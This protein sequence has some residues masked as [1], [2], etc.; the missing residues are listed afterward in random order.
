[1]NGTQKHHA[2]WKLEASD[3]MFYDSMCVKFLG[4]A[5]LDSRPM[6]ACSGDGR[7][8]QLT[9]NKGICFLFFFVV[10]ENVPKLDYGDWLHNYLSLLRLIE[11]IVYF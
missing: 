3:D 5:K 7:E 6:V 2:K 1:M 10:M 11:F 8:W 4:K 9:T